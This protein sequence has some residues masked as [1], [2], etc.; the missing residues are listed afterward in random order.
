MTKN[1]GQTA[2][3]IAIKIVQFDPVRLFLSEY[4]GVGDTTPSAVT[5]LMVKLLIKKLSTCFLHRPRKT[6]LIETHYRCE[7]LTH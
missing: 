2:R 7:L 6:Q 5:Q 3:E 4:S 1:D